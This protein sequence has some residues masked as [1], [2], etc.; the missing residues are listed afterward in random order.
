[1][2]KFLFSSFSSYQDLTKK[3]CN[4]LREEAFFSLILLLLKCCF[5]GLGSSDTLKTAFDQKSSYQV[6]KNRYIY[7]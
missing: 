2:K 4:I 3:L 6:E 7:K 1:M 5:W